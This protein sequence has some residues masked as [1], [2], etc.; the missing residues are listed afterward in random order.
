MKDTYKWSL[1]V[2]LNKADGLKT[3]RQQAEKW[4]YHL[5]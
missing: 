3:A 4:I 1:A 2:S 5:A